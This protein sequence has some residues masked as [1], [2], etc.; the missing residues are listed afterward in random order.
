MRCAVA[1]LSVVA[2]RRVRG[3]VSV[4]IE[5]G[6]PAH[7]VDSRYVNYNIDTGSLFNGMD[8]GDA[9]FRALVTNLG[10]AIIRIGGTA[11]DA[12]YYFPDTPYL[13]GQIND[14]TAC[15]YGASAIGR[16][17]LGAVFDFIAATNNSLL[18]DVN[19]EMARVG[20]G[21]WLPARNFTPMAQYLDATY[22]GR[23]D[24]AYSVGVRR[25]RA[26]RARAS[27]G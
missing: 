4:D 14:C 2:A 24:Y 25:R 27:A 18:W 1:L 19:G 20:T 15:G 12:S 23:V 17:M 16:E 11:V 9:K 7:I 5:A 3:D 21:P 26:P 13:V 8:F 22:G 10:P 6:A